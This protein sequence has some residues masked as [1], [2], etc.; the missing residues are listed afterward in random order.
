MSE[1]FGVIVSCEFFLKFFGMFRMMV[2]FG[3]LI[4]NVVGGGSQEIDELEV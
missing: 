2:F 1:F 3:V 4:V